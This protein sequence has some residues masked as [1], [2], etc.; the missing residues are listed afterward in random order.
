MSIQSALPGEL[1]PCINI[2]VLS[3]ELYPLI[4]CPATPQAIGHLG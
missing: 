4:Y 2:L 1:P 3:Y